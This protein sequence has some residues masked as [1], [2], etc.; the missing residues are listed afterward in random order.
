MFTLNTLLAAT[1]AAGA[2]LAATQTGVSLPWGD[3]AAAALDVVGDNTGYIVSGLVLWGLKSP[4][5]HIVAMAQTF[6]VDQILE[7]AI[8]A[9]VN[10]VE[11]AVKGRSL[12]FDTG[13]LVLNE[14]LT[15]AIR[16]APNFL[17]QFIG[18]WDDVARMIWAR[19]DLDENASAP[20]FALVAAK[21]ERAAKHG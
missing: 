14:A 6:R 19:L 12:D 8:T 13:S 7:K 9:G 20:D 3:W 15:Y 1:A 10:S 5:S 16:L 18:G 2:T 11:K 4:F 21:A 17:G